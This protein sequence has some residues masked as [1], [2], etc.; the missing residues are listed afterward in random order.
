[1]N[2][3]WILVKVSRWPPHG[4]VNTLSMLRDS[5]CNRLLDQNWHLYVY[6]I[7]AFIQYIYM[8][9]KQNLTL[10]DYLSVF[11]WYCVVY[12]YVVTCCVC[13]YSISVCICVSLSSLAVRT[14][15]PV[16]G[17]L[18]VEWRML[19]AASASNLPRVLPTTCSVSSMA[20]LWQVGRGA[21]GGDVC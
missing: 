1:M 10:D 11:N 8:S 20:L 18:R 2:C 5:S 4:T 13:V 6:S 21:C 16:K 3:G 17:G 12:Y 15:T 14:R 7:I 9:N 19:T